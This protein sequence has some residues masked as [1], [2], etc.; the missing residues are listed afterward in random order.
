MPDP[1]ISQTEGAAPAAPS[2]ANAASGLDL[3]GLT[4]VFTGGTVAVD[5]VNLHV[6]HGEY[7]VLLG[8]SGCGKTTTLR[9]IG[10]HEFPTA[11]DIVLDGQS[12]VDLPPAQAADDDR[13]PALRPLP[14]PLGAQQRRVR[15][16]DARRR[17]GR[18]AEAGVRGARHG[19]PDAAR[20]P[21]AEGALGRAAAA[22]RARAGPRHEAEGAP[23]RRAARRP[24]PPAP[25]ADARRAAQPPAP[26]RA[27]VHPRHAQPGRGALDGRSHRGHE[28]GSH[29]AGR[30]PA[31]DRD[32]A[33]HRSRR[34]V[35]G[36]QQHHPGHGHRA[37]GRPAGRRGR[38]ARTRQ[39]AGSRERAGRRRP[40]HGRRPRRCG[41]RSTRTAP[42]RRGSIRPSARSSSSSSSATSS[43]C[44][45]SPAASA[46]SPRSAP[47]STRSCAVARASGSGSP[48]RRR[49]SSSS[50]PERPGDEAN[51][52]ALDEVREAEAILDQRPPKTEAALGDGRGGR[53]GGG[54]GW[55][56]A[57]LAAPGFLWIG[58]Y[59]IAPLVIIVLVSFWTWTDAGFERTWTTAN[60]S[61]LFH[62][63]TYW[64]NMLSTLR[65]VG[66]RGRGVSRPRVPGRVL[67]RPQGREPA[68]PDRA[69][70]HRP[71]PVLD[72]LP[73]ARDRLDVPAHGPRGSAEPGADQAPDHLRAGPGVRLLDALGQA[74]HDPALHPVHDHAAL[75]LAGT[76]RPRP[77]SR[78]HATSAA[79]GGR[80]S[81]R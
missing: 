27:D 21:Q 66:D 77:P 52:L 49:M 72:E 31:D 47:S 79:T 64:D 67:P 8:P 9:M 74:G 6:D 60:Y 30:R 18:A 10:G 55:V 40:G 59:L 16:Q 7:V 2:P 58:F 81:G 5:D 53:G 50:T 46:C 4:K 57:A 26:A 62:D 69:L 14:A 33:R 38:A 68:E 37:R 11:G 42:R 41:R 20:R 73:H 32:E 1:G 80:R 45:C 43:S 17:Q 76:G 36:R 3:V 19:R 56:T 34:S 23:A 75:L 25:V 54:G 65:D 29:P 24:R 39:R 63:S 61:E 28:R 22:R 13:L 12:L 78:P 35:H 70:H 51:R 71:G 48:G 44:T 15:P